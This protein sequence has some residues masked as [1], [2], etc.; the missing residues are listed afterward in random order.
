[1]QP[2]GQGPETLAQVDR[3]KL[4]NPD[5]SRLA[6]GA[7][8][9]FRLPDGEIASADP[10]VSVTAGALE[11]SNVNIAETLVN[12]I[13]LARMYEMQIN[14]IKTAKEDADVAAQMMQLG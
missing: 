4:V 2:I 8:G 9:L 3:I 12:M 10:A 13:S 11:Q 5:V 6:K 1:V 7:D 14:V